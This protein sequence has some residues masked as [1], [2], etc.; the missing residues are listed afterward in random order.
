MNHTHPKAGA[1]SQATTWDLSGARLVAANFLLILAL[2][3][4]SDGGHSTAVVAGTVSGLA[5]GQSVVLQN[6]GSDDTTVTTDGPFAFSI[7]VA[8]GAPYSVSVLTQP[9]GQTCVA[10][11]AGGIAHSDI[12]ID[13]SVTCSANAYTIGVTVAGLTGTGLVVQNNGGDPLSISAN[14]SH[15]FSV[16]VDSGSPYDVTVLSQPTGQQCSVVGGTGTV[17]AAAVDVAVNCVALPDSWNWVGGSN[18][19]N[20]PGVYGTLNVGAPGNIPGARYGSVSWKDSSG[21]FWLFGGVGYDSAGATGSLNDL[22]EY[23]AGQW[24]WKGGSDTINAS[25][26]YG[27]KGVAAADNIPGA[28]FAAVLSIDL[29]GNV[30]L[31]GGNTDPAGQNRLLNDLWEYSNGQWTWV[32]GSDTVNATGTYGT[33]GTAAAA[34]VPG[35]RFAHVSWIDSAGNFWLFG[36]LG[37]DSTGAQGFQNDLWKYSAGQWTWVSGSSTLQA[38]GTYGTEGV[39]APANVP[40]ARLRPVSWFDAA[41]DFWLFGGLGLDSTGT[42]GGLNDLWRYSAGQW[43]WMGGSDTVNA[44][45]TYGTKGVAAPGNIPGARLAA[46]AWLDS[47]GNVWLHGGQSPDPLGNP[48]GLNDLWE[49]C[50]GQWKWVSGSDTPN[51]S[52][53]YGTQGT[54]AVD[55]VPGSRYGASSWLDASDHLWLFGGAGLDSAG[56]NGGLNDLWEYAP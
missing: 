13:V 24:I 32:S 31:S 29:S 51:A 21:N 22:W 15:Q 46:V 43:T 28:R 52:G 26:I 14:G 38:S 3:A 56:T 36:G 20:S 44:A 9:V 40:G 41:G 49:Y 34:N 37:F 54:A 39:A 6:I 47:S 8:S 7:P 2:S 50:A 23:S 30:W 42:F 12:A 10:A 45:G 25:G 11:N 35:A 48:I 1:Q 17:A 53:S 27:T 33:Q 5:A 19:A 18:L 55:N 16:L 4:C